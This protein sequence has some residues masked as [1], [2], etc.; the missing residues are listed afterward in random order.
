MLPAAAL[1]RIRSEILAKKPGFGLERSDGAELSARFI[2]RFDCPLGPVW[3]A[4]LP[5]LGEREVVLQVDEPLK[6]HLRVGQRMLDFS[7]SVVAPQA[8]LERS[9]CEHERVILIAE[10]TDY[11]EVQRRRW[12]RAGAEEA[13]FGAASLYFEGS[14]VIAGEDYELRRGMQQTSVNVLDISGGG[15]SFEAPDSLGHE[16]Q[17]GELIRIRIDLQGGQEP[18]GFS[19]QV[20]NRRRCAGGLRY[21]VA[22]YGDDHLFGEISAR[23]LHLVFLTQSGS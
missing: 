10:P 21:G 6:G 15:I 23:A 7:T 5:M 12:H 14:R 19:A 13:I 22:F 20:R 18:F 11:A 9:D 17:I 8:S 4:S 16:L 3:L 2:D 1:Q